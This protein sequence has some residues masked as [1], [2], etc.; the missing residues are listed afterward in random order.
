MVS[1][2]S[3]I[4]TIYERFKLRWAQAMVHSSFFGWPDEND[5][6]QFNGISVDVLMC[7]VQN[8]IG[9]A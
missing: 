2:M 4:D 3:A 9:T 1:V 7:H 5:K 6:Q 8:S